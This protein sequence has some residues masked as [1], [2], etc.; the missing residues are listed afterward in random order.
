MT[1][2]LSVWPSGR[3]CD[4]LAQTSVL[5]LQTA[6]SAPVVKGHVTFKS[7]HVAYHV[8][9][10]HFLFEL[11]CSP[12]S[13]PF[14]H[15]NVLENLLCSLLFKLALLLPRGAVKWREGGRG[16]GREGR[17]EGGE[18][19]GREGS[20]EGGGRPYTRLLTNCVGG[21]RHSPND[22]RFSD[23]CCLSLLFLVL[24]PSAARVW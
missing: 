12:L 10:L 18:R 13:Y 3:T 7:S 6:S 5:S 19:G 16:E 2:S 8:T 20:R 22:G 14:C 15:L 21:S 23:K 17:G 4:A 9:N 11:F 24:V 1:W